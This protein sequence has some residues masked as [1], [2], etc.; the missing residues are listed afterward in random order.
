MRVE[1]R[2]NLMSVSITEET[3]FREREAQT[4]ANNRLIN[5]YFELVLT[6]DYT[7]F[8]DMITD[9]CTFAFMPIGHTF[10]GRRDVM[11]FILATG[12]TRK[13]DDKSRIRITNW[14]TTGDYFCLEHVHELIINLIHRR[15]KIDGYC[16]VFHMRDGKFDTIR[17]YLNPSSLGWSFFATVIL[18]ILPLAAKIKARRMNLSGG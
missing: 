7:R 5:E 14:F 6:D 13:H 4:E 18:R 12:S 9:E 17:E 16:L 15:T 1:W 10:K 2:K 8:G 3:P 11:R